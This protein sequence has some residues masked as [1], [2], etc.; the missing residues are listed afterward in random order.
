MVSCPKTGIFCA[1][2]LSCILFKDWV[3][4]VK[5]KTKYIQ[6]NAEEYT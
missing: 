2:A 3:Q 6:I 5:N 1:I 4:F